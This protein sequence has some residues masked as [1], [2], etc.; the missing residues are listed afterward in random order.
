MARRV[1][2]SLAL[3]AGCSACAGQG[4]ELGERQTTLSTYADRAA[5]SKKP[6]GLEPVDVPQFV[7]VTFDDNFVSGLG[8]DSGGM[9]WA[10]SFFEP[11]RNPAGSGF[12]PTFDGSPA[13]TS[14]Y[15]NCLYLD[16]ESTRKSWRTARDHG[17][18]LG[19]HTV[20]HL[21]G[22][23]F[24]AAD[25]TEQIA[26]CTAA[27]TKSENGLGVGVDDV[28]GFRA[29]FLE[30]S[31]ELFGALQS[32]GLW[33]DTSVQSCWGAG[34]DGTS[35]AWPYTLDQ[36]S[37]DGV[38]LTAKFQTP[39]VPPSAGLWELT[40]SALFVPPDTLAAQYGFEPGL[41][42]RI[43]ADMP[44]PSFY[45]AT[46][47]RIAPLDVTLFVDA[48]LSP[49]EVLA[50]LKYTLDLRLQGNRAPLIFIGHTHVYAS[51]YGAAAKAPDAS[52]RQRVIEDFVRYAQT[53]PVVR[54]RPVADILSWMQRPQPL[55]G[56]VTAPVG[57]ATA[58]AGGSVSAGGGV[59]GGT[60]D[61]GGAGGF[62]GSVAGNPGGGATGAV[63]G[64]NATIASNEAACSCG[65]V[66]NP[67]KSGFGYYATWLLLA[68]L[69]RSAV[70]LRRPSY[71]CRECRS[72]CPGLQPNAMRWER[73]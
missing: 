34:D 36:G 32:Q 9:T 12:A 23:Q 57:S 68:L 58:G 46:T 65:V 71:T 38:N 60:A 26:P 8:D 31:S 13:R 54:L 47:G 2:T 40:P 6:P 17:H 20:S 67:R 51:N 10:T 11:L 69:G 27:L 73:S 61:A 15:G 42:Q 64:S 43:P 56:V 1:S 24:T 62:A 22:G 63:A 5:W 50:T 14:F 49:A 72:R 44:A 19:N 41:R 55:N 66:G 29:P 30:Y 39:T 45:E 53:L 21:H 59:A 4:P 16:D 52:A 3:L 28:R 33:Y 37:P 35:C 48:G 70:R 18:E 7:A 25:W